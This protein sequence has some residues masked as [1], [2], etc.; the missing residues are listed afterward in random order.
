MGIS[1]VTFTMDTPLRKSV[2]QMYGPSSVAAG[3]NVA[4]VGPRSVTD[5]VGVEGG[6]V[7]FGIRIVTVLLLLDRLPAASTA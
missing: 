4:C 2:Y 7:S 3:S 6:I 5:R 1:R